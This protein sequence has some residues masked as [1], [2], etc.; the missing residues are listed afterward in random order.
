MIAGLLARHPSRLQR[1][2]TDLR[3]GRVPEHVFGD[4]FRR[5]EAA[6][7]REQMPDSNGRFAI[8]PELRDKSCDGI[9]PTQPPLLLLLGNRHGSDRLGRRKPEH[10][11]VISHAATWRAFPECFVNNDF[12]VE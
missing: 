12:T 4:P 10:K 9:F 6:S 8:L 5:T 2:G 7:M 11:I 1:R 3:N